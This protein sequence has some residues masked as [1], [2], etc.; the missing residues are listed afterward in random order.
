MITCTFEGVLPFV[1]NEATKER[2]AL[3]AV[4]SVTVFVPRLSLDLR[5]QGCR[6]ADQISP[7]TMYQHD[8]RPYTNPTLGSA[9]TS[10]LYSLH[11]RINT[12]D[13]LLVCFRTCGQVARCFTTVLLVWSRFME[14]CLRVC[15]V[16]VDVLCAQLLD[17]LG[18]I[19]PLEDLL[20]KDARSALWYALQ[21]AQFVHTCES[22]SIAASDEPL[23]PLPLPF[24]ASFDCA[25][26]EVGLRA[27]PTWLPLVPL[28]LRVSIDS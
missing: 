17:R 4:R 27:C 13:S 6:Q 3:P 23:P 25:V 2:N 28:D 8:I 26:G 7:C 18:C 14:R 11:I 21:N 20:D 9:R 16:R 15:R 10:H 12:G 19:R 22:G 5:S 1:A 24:D